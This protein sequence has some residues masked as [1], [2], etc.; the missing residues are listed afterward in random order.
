MDLYEAIGK[1]DLEA[2][3]MLFVVTGGGALGEKALFAG[4]EP[5][6]VSEGGAFF[7]A[8]KDLFA[9]ITQNGTITVDGKE[10]FCELLGSEKKLVVCGGGHVGAEV[11]GLAKTLGFR[12]I[13]VEDREE[14]A[15]NARKRG[16]D[17]VIL[18]GYEE[19]ID[20]IE[21]DEDTYFV[22][23]TRG[24][25]S[26]LECVRAA[27]KKAR[28]YVGMIGSRNH[29]VVVKEALLKEGVPED[30]VSALHAPIGLPIGSQTPEEIAVSIMAEIIKV[31]NTEYRSSGFSKE[32]MKIL[33]TEG[34]GPVALAVITKLE[35]S[36]PRGTGTRML[37]RADG[38]IVGT[39][40]G[41][42]LEAAAIA[43]AKEMIASGEKIYLL[44]MEMTNSRAEEEGMVCGGRAD[45]LLETV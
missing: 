15:E 7:E 19:A 12:V 36:G 3:T 45:I 37:I 35:G 38:S 5:V 4:G 20:G 41:G 28:A 39:I 26:D 17:E 29:A 14:F 34:R 18:G 10:V 24:H 30:T 2:K 23:V 21:S 1:R 32:M 9:G 43:K 8:R 44:H 40:G 6:W 42:G 27:M 31:K 13:A 16:A 11:V 25:R 22:V 33:L